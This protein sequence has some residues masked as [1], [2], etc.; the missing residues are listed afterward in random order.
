M[1]RAQKEGRLDWWWV[2][3]DFPRNPGKFG[4]SSEINGAPS[5]ALNTAK[6]SSILVH[7][8]LSGGVSKTA[9]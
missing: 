6:D 2:G 8:S 1:F 3:R 7:F 5:W 4:K 9:A